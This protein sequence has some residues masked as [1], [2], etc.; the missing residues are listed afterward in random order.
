MNKVPNNSGK[1]FLSPY[2]LPS[3]WESN[4]KLWLSSEYTLVNSKCKVVSILLCTRKGKGQL[5]SCLKYDEYA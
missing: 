3:G 2:S 4:F 5:Y 1:L